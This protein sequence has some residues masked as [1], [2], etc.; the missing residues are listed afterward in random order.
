[1]L[2]YARICAIKVC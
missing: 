2:G 1:M